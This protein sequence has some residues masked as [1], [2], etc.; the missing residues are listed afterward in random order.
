MAYLVF[1]SGRWI[2]Y[3]FSPPATV[4]ISGHLDTATSGLP[5][6]YAL[7]VTGAVQRRG[8]PMEGRV[9]ISVQRLW[10]DSPQTIETA[11]MGGKFELPQSM[12]FTFADRDERLLI[13]AEAWA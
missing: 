4:A 1:A 7:H 5:E 13:T 10:Q 8:N 2:Y 11:L 9:I 3:R 12:E 6:Q